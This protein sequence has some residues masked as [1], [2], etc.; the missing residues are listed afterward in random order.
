MI[1]PL[2]LTVISSYC[3]FLLGRHLSQRHEDFLMQEIGNLN[4]MRAD[5]EAEAKKS[6]SKVGEVAAEVMDCRRRIAK[7]E[8]ANAELRSEL[9]THRDRKLESQKHITRLTELIAD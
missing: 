3:F 5:A 9:Q 7:A 6:A 4:R 1:V 2:I 8:A